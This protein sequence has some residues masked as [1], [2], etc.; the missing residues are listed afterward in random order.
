MFLLN[1]AMPMVSWSVLD[2]QRVP[3]LAY[4]TLA[5]ACR[6]VIITADRLPI[7]MHPGEE[8]RIAI[9]AVSDLREDLKDAIVSATLEVA[10]VPQVWRWEG[11]IAGDDCSLVGHITIS[12]SFAEGPLV[13][14]L[15]L[16]CGEVVA[17]NRYH[18]EV[19]ART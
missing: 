5:E 8:I 2:H 7:A 17:T 11:D 13:L 14:D 15:T 6:Q 19:V 12:A 3:K 16:E 10:G 9:H 18:S 4:T 1:D